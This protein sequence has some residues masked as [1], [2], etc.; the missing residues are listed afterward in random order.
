MTVWA[1]FSAE[2]LT[3]SDGVP[4]LVRVSG[5][6]VYQPMKGTGKSVMSGVFAAVRGNLLPI[7][8]GAP[9]EFS[10]PFSLPLPLPNCTS[11][12]VSFPFLRSLHRPCA[13]LQLLYFLL[14]YH[15]HDLYSTI[16]LLRV[17]HGQGPRAQQHITVPLQRI[18]RKDTTFI[19]NITVLLVSRS[20]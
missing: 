19:Q 8:Y 17:S 12:P 13:R 7:Q 15:S 18:A 6:T 2:S 9:V 1:L 10:F 3:A 16:S 5:E 20:L 4:S 14:Q 11:P